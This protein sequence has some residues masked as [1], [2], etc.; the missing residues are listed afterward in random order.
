[1]NEWLK[2]A[3]ALFKWISV[4]NNLTRLVSE[5]DSFFVSYLESKDLH[6]R[7]ILMKDLKVMYWFH[8]GFSI[9]YLLTNISP[10]FLV[11]CNLFIMF[12]VAL[13]ILLLLCTKLGSFQY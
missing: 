3:L 13:H 8:E 4:L 10:L 7:Q 6:D 12:G 11:C 1:M 9:G 5:N 2:F